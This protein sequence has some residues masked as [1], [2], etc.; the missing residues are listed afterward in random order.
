M[1]QFTT[2]VSQIT[3]YLHK[4]NSD[5]S[6]PFDFSE[7]MDGCF[8][9]HTIETILEIT[10][11][12]AKLI[13]Y[14][15][16]DFKNS[17]PLTI[18]AELQYN[19]FPSNIKLHEIETRMK[20]G[21]TDR[22]LWRLKHKNKSH[23]IVEVETCLVDKYFDQNL[24]VTK[25]VDTYNDSFTPL[26]DQFDKNKFKSV[27]DPSYESV[28]LINKNYIIENANLTA[29]F[30]FDYSISEITKSNFLKLVH[31]DNLPEFKSFLE[32][33]SYSH[34]CSN[35]PCIFYNTKHKSVFKGVTN[36]IRV[37][38]NSDLCYLVIIRKA[39][40]EKEL[41]ELLAETSIRAEED[42]RSRYI[43][44]LHDGLGPI[45]TTCRTYA[46][47]SRT[48]KD[49][50]K[51]EQYI[52]RI[53]ELLGDGI[54]SINDIV[55]NRLPVVLCDKGLSCAIETYIEKLN[56]ISG[57]KV[58][59]NSELKDKFADHIKITLYRII[60][61]LINNT[62]KHATATEIKINLFQ[63]SNTINCMYGDNGKGLQKNFKPGYGLTSIS[64][65]ITGIGGQISIN[66]EN[67][68]GLKIHI[69]ITS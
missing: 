4:I 10:Y 41:I 29:C 13:G 61:E 39:N 48:V 26:I 63:E 44:E 57:L 35:W 54:Q 56:L 17:H 20:P 9:L 64:E 47:I 6:F 40:T 8:L 42:E 7:G 50:E 53:Y 32:N 25:W 24:Y 3:T 15:P 52:N 34:L 28:F 30:N 62:I 66:T 37:T 51:Q 5:T 36:F 45:L 12:A 23:K 58:H 16:E 60:I 46:S 67:D 22:F 68:N 14:M 38:Y 43:K 19:N 69:K 59:Y 2:N 18:S 1:V 11:P 55:N 33:S 65:R 27:F 31:P 21:Q 49:K